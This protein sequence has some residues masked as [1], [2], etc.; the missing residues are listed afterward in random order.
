MPMIRAC[1]GDLFDS[2]NVSAARKDTCKLRPDI[3]FDALTLVA[4]EDQINERQ[5]KWYR[6][7]RFRSSF[8]H[9]YT[10]ARF[11]LDMSDRLFIE[12]VAVLK[13]QAH[14]SCDRQCM[15]CGT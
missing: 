4:L 10:I 11:F 3:F 5:V 2:I 8:K 13:D 9:G 6:W 15:G 1:G 7:R 14:D 12:P